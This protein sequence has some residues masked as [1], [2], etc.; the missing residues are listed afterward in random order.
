MAR[1][2]LNDVV[3]VQDPLQTWNWDLFLPNIPGSGLSRDITIK[4][5]SSTIP[6]SS[7]EQVGVEAHGVKLNFAGR[8]TWSGTW[9]ATFFESRNSSTRTAF[10]QW[11]EFMRSWANNSGTYKQQYSVTGELSLYDDLPQVVK[12]I[13]LV[14]M[15][16]QQVDDVSLDQTSGV[17][18]YQVTFSYDYT[19]D[20]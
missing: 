5:V 11:L 1:T 17:I 18:Q 10:I 14:G 16:V 2:G 6:G 20:V 15:F 7:V 3:S 8:R 13:K 19:I 12:G 9:S 4:C